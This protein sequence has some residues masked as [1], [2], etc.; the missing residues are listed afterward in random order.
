MDGMRDG[1]KSIGIPDMDKLTQVPSNLV[2]YK[3]KPL[4]YS[5]QRFVTLGNMP[6]DYPNI[7][8]LVEYETQKK[9]KSC[10]SPTFLP[11]SG[12]IQ[13]SRNA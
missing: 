4:K 12:F 5:L 9:G 11:Q 8:K 13:Y 7:E 2:I 1:G 10:I 6:A 3:T